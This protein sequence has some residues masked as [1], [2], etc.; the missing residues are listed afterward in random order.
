MKNIYINPFKTLAILFA[1]ITVSSCAKFLET[2]MPTNSL[3]TKTAFSSKTTI[4][5]MMNQMYITFV[6]NVAITTSFNMEAY[7]DNTYNPT[8]SSTPQTNGDQMPVP[9]ASWNNLYRAIY[10]ANTMLEGLPDANAVGLTQIIRDQYIAAALTVRSM[11][12]F[13]LVRFYG[14]VPLLLTSDV[15]ANKF[16]ARTPKAEIYTKIETDLKQAITLLPATLGAKYYITNKYIPEAILANV[17]LTQG[18]WTDA[19]AAATDIIGSGKF[20]LVNIA[21][22]FLQKSAETIMATG[23]TQYANDKAL[24]AAVPG[25]YGCLPAGSNKKALETSFPSLSESLVTSFET[26]DL[27]RTNWTIVSNTNGYSNPLNR[28]FSYKYKYNT[29]MDAT[30]V[31]PVGREEDQK[32]MRLAEMYLVRAEARASKTSPDLTGAAAD[33]NLIRNRAGLVNTTA[34]TQSALVDAIIKERR[35]ELFYEG[36]SRWCDLVRTNKADAILGAISYKASNWKSHMKLFPIPIAEIQKN[37]ELTQN[38]GYN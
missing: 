15:E 7:A 23:Y 25:A 16:V 2:P 24:Q 13:Q 29:G 8:S 4:D 11:A 33:L 12:Y 31:I 17:Y 38:P 3:A 1:L 32:F 20:Q 26:G 30:V 37:P 18:K 21:D 36:F 5:G 27:R 14:D 19:E 34:A 6:N 9:S 28:V 10:L 22:V 35:V